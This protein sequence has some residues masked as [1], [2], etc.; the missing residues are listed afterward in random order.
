MNE[1]SGAAPSRKILGF[2]IRVTRKNLI[3]RFLEVAVNAVNA[4]SC[5]VVE[6]CCVEVVVEVAGAAWLRC[7]GQR[8]G[9]EEKF[10]LPL[11][12]EA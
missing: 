11:P 4:M 5:H 12:P 1:K 3:L 9:T 10:S 6:S 7:P 8:T 2:F